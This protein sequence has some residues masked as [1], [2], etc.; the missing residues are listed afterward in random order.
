M[1]EK[2][3]G[4]LKVTLAGW[5]NGYWSEAEEAGVVAEIRKSRPD[6]LFV[7]MSS[8]KKEMFLKRWKNELQ[9]PFVM[10]V[11]GTFD[12][13]AGYVKRAPRWM[14]ACGLEWLYRLGQEPRRMWRRYLVDDMA[15]LGLLAREV[16][17]LRFR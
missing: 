15:F 14:Q 7:A 9:V 11:G 16:Y 1:V 8:P 10:G 12:V 17:R 3:A 6:V 2:A 4:S 5:R 13:V